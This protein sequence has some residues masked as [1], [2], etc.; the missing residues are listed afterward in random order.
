[1]KHETPWNPGAVGEAAAAGRGPEGPRVWPRGD[2]PPLEDHPSERLRLAAA[3]SARRNRCPGC[4][5][6]AGPPVE[7]DGAAEAGLGGLPSK[8]SLR[9]R[10]CHG[11]LEPPPHR[12]V[13]SPALGHRVP[14]QGHSPAD[15]RAVFLLL[16]SPNGRSVSAKRRPPAVGFRGAGRESLGDVKV[17]FIGSAAGPTQSG[18][19]L[20]CGKC[21]RSRGAGTL[22]ATRPPFAPPSP[23]CPRPQ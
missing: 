4:Q 21:G 23:P 10:I 22:C 14:H 9:L 7:T 6:G 2:R 15:G 12:R 13:D 11:P 8:R 16:N 1:M 19:G 18:G 17:K 3:V 5:A 20:R